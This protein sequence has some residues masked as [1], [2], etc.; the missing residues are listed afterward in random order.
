MHR[1]TCLRYTNRPHA[2]PCTAPRASRSAVAL[3]AA[4]R[5]TV[6]YQETAEPSEEQMLE[7]LRIVRDKLGEAV[8]AR[9]A[10]MLGVDVSATDDNNGPEDLAP[11]E[12]PLLSPRAL[13]NAALF[14]KGELP[15]E[16]V[17]RR[18]KA[19]RAQAV[20]RAYA[21]GRA[22]A[23]SRAAGVEKR[24]AS[25]EAQLGVASPSDAPEVAAYAACGQLAE[26]RHLATVYA[27][28]PSFVRRTPLRDYLA[29]QIG[30]PE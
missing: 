3:A 7:A 1:P 20:A 19:M 18:A 13:S 9:L 4:L 10:L 30:S 27:A 8:A 29:G 16:A 28:S 14:P 2:G 5:R 11:S 23:T 12:Q 24:V 17:S 15:H 6:A 21:A 22:A 25:L 26:A